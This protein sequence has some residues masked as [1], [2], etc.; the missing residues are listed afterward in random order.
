VPRV[1]VARRRHGRPLARRPDLGDDGGKRLARFGRDPSHSR[2]GRHGTL[3]TG[4]DEASPR[5]G[6]RHPGRRV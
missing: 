1:R 2:S 5:P 4:E 3:L 6:Q